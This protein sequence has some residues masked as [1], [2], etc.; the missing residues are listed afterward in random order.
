MKLKKEE[1][2]ITLAGGPAMTKNALESREQSRGQES[3]ETSSGDGI[4][5]T[6]SLLS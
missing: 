6:K 5:P 3:P 4:S 1:E 2:I